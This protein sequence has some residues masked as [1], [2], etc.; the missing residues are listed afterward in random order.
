MNTKPWKVLLTAR[1]LADVGAPAIDLLNK[2][3]C[4]LVHSQKKGPLATAGLLPQL[5]GIDAVLCSPDKFTAEVFSSPAARNLKI[6]SRWG[7]GYDSVDVAA[8]TAAGVVVAFTP[9]MLNDAVADYAFALMLG[10][11]RRIHEGHLC[12]QEGRWAAAWG[13]DIARKTLGIIGCGR[14]GQAMAR[15][16]SGFEMRLLGH[17]VMKNPDAEKLGVKFV[18]LDELLEQS[19]FV[20]LHAALTPETKNMIGE[21]Q[22]RKMKRSAYLINTARG[23][24]IDEA[25]LVK[26]LK[27][28]WIAGAAV[29][30]FVTEPLPSEHPFR[31]APNLLFTP[32]QAAFARETGE[33]VSRAS[34]Q[35]I[36][37]LMNG[38]R[39]QYVVDAN[40][41]ESPAL[42]AKLN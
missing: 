40:V 5:E 29:D 35:A 19:D 22:L 15:R 33:Q 24:H 37:D 39:P 18:S 11:A 13:H 17:D 8:A 4:G 16:A 23:A 20:S 41:F 21:A 36:V 6:V 10:I 27:E 2:A 38:R 42:R 9:G 25:A 32:H 12:M 1:A 31:S 28:G 3:G 14:I 34:A 26:A 7:V 30:T